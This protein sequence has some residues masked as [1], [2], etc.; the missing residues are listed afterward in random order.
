MIHTRTRPSYMAL[1]ERSSASSRVAGPPAA[2]S[3][4]EGAADLVELPI[5]VRRFHPAKW[6]LK[7]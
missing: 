5:M 2:A 7:Q 4:V 1:P 6:P 3:Q